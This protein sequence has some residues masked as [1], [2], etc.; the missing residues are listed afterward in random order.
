[1]GRR[2]KERREEGGASSTVPET[3]SRVQR[4]LWVVMRRKGKKK[5][6]SLVAFSINWLQLWADRRPIAPTSETVEG[7]GQGWAGRKPLSGTSPR[8]AS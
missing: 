2:G 7:W 1:M 6:K 4:A 3:W 8:E 5:R